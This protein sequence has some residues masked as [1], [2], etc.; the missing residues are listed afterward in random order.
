MP[1]KVSRQNDI[2][3]AIQVTIR[4]SKLSTGGGPHDCGS[5]GRIILS[6]Q[7]FAD[8]FVHLTDAPLI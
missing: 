3:P 4:G 1:L 5:R 6:Q 7:I 2:V 8:Y